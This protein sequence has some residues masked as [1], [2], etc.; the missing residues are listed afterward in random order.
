MIA[1][2]VQSDLISH[3]QFLT[4]EGKARY[5]LKQVNKITAISVINN[6]SFRLN[7]TV[8]DRA[9]ESQ[10]KIKVLGSTARLKS[11]QTARLQQSVITR[12][13]FEQEERAQQSLLTARIDEKKEIHQ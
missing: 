13:D 9:T 11:S 10:A 3:Q 6:L 1:V 8:F 2:V 12:Y 5:K 7:V 4:L